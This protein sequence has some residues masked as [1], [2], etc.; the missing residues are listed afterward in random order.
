MPLT[1]IQVALYLGIISAPVKWP[2]VVQQG[3]GSSEGS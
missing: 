1:T 2:F 3:G